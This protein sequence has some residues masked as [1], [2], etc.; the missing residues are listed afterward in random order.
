MTTQALRDE[1]GHDYGPPAEHFARTVAILAIVFGDTP[2]YALSPQDW[3]LVMVCDKL[4]RFANTRAHR[5]SMQDIAGY[6]DCWLEVA[7]GCD[8][9]RSCAN[10]AMAC[11]RRDGLC[12]NWWGG[13]PTP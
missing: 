10:C 7:Q 1:R 13:E 12:A 6:A 3:A 5:D 9:S 4:A 8:E 11:G 2:V